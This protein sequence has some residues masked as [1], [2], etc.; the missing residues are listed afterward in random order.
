MPILSRSPRRRRTDGFTLVELATAIVVIAIL[1]AVTTVAY[2]GVQNR[3]RSAAAAST[4]RNVADAVNVFEA[5]WHRLP[6]SIDELDEA[7]RDP[8]AQYAVNIAAQTYCIT[9]T[10]DTVSFFVNNM[11]Q[12]SPTEGICPEHST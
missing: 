6:T 2:N 8:Q 3:A 10:V 1:V 5:E 12:T 4:A 7:A 9:A 11:T